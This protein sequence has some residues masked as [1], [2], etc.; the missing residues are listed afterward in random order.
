MF[1]AAFTS[2]SW[3]APQS[4]Q[5]QSLIRKPAMPF[6]LDAGKLQHAE[7]VWEVNFSSIST[8]STPCL[9]ALYFSML[10][11][12][13]QLASN[14]DFAI[15]VLARADAETFPTAMRQLARTRSVEAL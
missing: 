7:Q 12:D 14:T 5:I 4:S 8:Y 13:D 9:M 11:N 15:L 1:K 3:T 6:G 2:R 10:R